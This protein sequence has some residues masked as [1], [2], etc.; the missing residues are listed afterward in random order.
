MQRALSL[1]AK[2]PLAAEAKLALASRREGK[3]P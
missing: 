3:K 1:D 2:S